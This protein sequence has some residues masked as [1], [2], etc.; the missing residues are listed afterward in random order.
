MVAPSVALGVGAGV[1]EGVLAT[2]VGVGAGD[3]LP[4]VQR[5]TPDVMTLRTAAPQI[6][7]ITPGAPSPRGSTLAF[8]Q[9]V[10]RRRGPDSI[11]S[12]CFSILLVSH[13]AAAQEFE[14]RH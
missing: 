7:R 14:H 3:E 13:S 4:D 11:L 12:V 9:E 8:R 1:G 6:D 2:G 10:L 5:L